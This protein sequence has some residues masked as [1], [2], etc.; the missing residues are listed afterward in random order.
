MTQLLAQD[1][2]DYLTFWGRRS[3]DVRLGEGRGPQCQPY[4]WE[5][6]RQLC[7]DMK[8]IVLLKAPLFRSRPVCLGA[9]RHPTGLAIHT[10]PSSNPQ[11]AAYVLET[12]G[13]SL[14]CG[15]HTSLWCTRPT[16]ANFKPPTHVKS[17]KTV[18]LGKTTTTARWPSATSGH[19]QS[20][21]Q[22]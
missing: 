1:G 22:P 16:V 15:A 19:R 14:C 18:S 12:Q 4:V 10:S 21:M 8:L 2:L 7:M 9:A 3:Q 17:L 5:P 11:W 6:P 13:N 20:E